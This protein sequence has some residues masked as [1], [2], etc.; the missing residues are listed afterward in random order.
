MKN[1]LLTFAKIPVPDAGR[2]I[3]VDEAVAASST[4][5]SWVVS[6]PPRVVM[7]STPEYDRFAAGSTAGIPADGAASNAR[8]MVAE[9]RGPAPVIIPSVHKPMG[10]VQLVVV[11]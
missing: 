8:N 7:V 10:L 3:S 5:R 4:P 2:S 9:S 1:T 11:K 6:V